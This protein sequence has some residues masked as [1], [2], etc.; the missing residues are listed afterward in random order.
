[1]AFTG[2]CRIHPGRYPRLAVEAKATRS[3][4]EARDLR[5]ALELRA[6]QL[7]VSVDELADRLMRQALGLAP[8]EP[9]KARKASAQC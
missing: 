3:A 6:A 2:G 9:A 1:M 7:H 5:Q 8:R 4:V